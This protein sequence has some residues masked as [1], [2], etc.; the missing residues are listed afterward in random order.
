MK[1]K[2]KVSRI[3]FRTLVSNIGFLFRYGWKSAPLFLLAALIY[4]VYQQVLIFF[5]HTY[6]IKFFIDSIQY[7]RP[8][9]PVLRYICVIAVLVTLNLAFGAFFGHYFKPLSLE[10]VYARMRRDFYTKAAEVDLECYDDPEYYNDFVWV[11]NQAPERFQT[12]LDETCSIIGAI[13]AISCAGV[14]IVFT[15]PA[16]LLFVAFSVVTTTWAETKLGKLKFAL[17]RERSAGQRKQSYVSRVFYTADSAKEIRLTPVS[18]RLFGEFKT[19]GDEIRTA[20][21]KHAP[22]QVRFGIFSDLLFQ[23]L[24]LEFFYSFWVIFRVLILHNLSYGDIVALLN[25]SNRMKN[26]L[27]RIASLVSEYNTAA[28][29]V[30]KVRAFLNRPPRIASPAKPRPLPESKWE[31]TLR[32]VCFCYPG[33]DRLILDHVSMVIPAG[34]SL[35]LVGH[36]GAGK[37]SL[38]KLLMRLYDPTS[39]SIFV[40]GIDIREFDPAEYRARVG[41][42]FQD[43]QLFATSVAENV[44]MESTAADDRRNPA[45]EM[46]LERSGF[47]GRLSKMKNG[48]STQITREFDDLGESLSGGEAQK[49]AIAR[50]VYK[51]AALSILDEPSSALDPISEYQLNETMQRASEDSTVVYISHRLST[52]RLADRVCLLEGGRIVEE[53]THEELMDADAAYAHMFNLQAE[54]YRPPEAR[55]NR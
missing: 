12:T 53:G 51:G 37:T 16:G 44:V 9:G 40:N 42:I 32:D 41:V 54:R 47:S 13:A 11:L 34:K 2:I 39:G 15:D 50:V 29:F 49:L 10:K 46:S 55:I 17:D 35:A 8:F 7:G 19:S 36:N 24:P 43:F 28:L 31:V 14:F 1:G 52:T 3:K 4:P 38:V 48:L 18:D 27:E 45:I 23:H 33:S 6:S 30:D 21:K 26:C 25:S 5:E 20:I 22:A